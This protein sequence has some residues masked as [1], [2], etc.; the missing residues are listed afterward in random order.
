MAVARITLTADYQSRSAGGSGPGEGRGRRKGTIGQRC[1]VSAHHSMIAP[2]SCADCVVIC[3]H[4]ISRQS[5]AGIIFT[6]QHHESTDFHRTDFHRIRLGCT[7]TCTPAS[8]FYSAIW[9]FLASGLPHLRVAVSTKPSRCRICVLQTMMFGE[10]H[11][12][13]PVCHHCPPRLLL[14]WAHLRT[15]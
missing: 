10:H 11:L 8:D 7:T 6:T 5:S 4:C 9:M 13:A 3:I 1:H 15:Y 14:C 12:L 2:G